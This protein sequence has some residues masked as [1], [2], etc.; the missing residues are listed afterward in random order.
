MIE[1]VS[2]DRNLQFV[3]G[4]EQAVIVWFNPTVDI[5]EDVVKRLD[6]KK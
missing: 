4:L 5:S 3:F 6:A 2:S 1:E